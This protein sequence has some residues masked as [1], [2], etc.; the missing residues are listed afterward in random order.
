MHFGTTTNFSRRTFLGMRV[1]RPRGT[2]RSDHRTSL[3]PTP[4]PRT[5]HDLGGL[6]LGVQSYTLR[7][8][9]SLEA[10]LD[11]IQK[12]LGL[13]YVELYPGHLTGKS[14]AQVKELLDAHKITLS[15]WGVIH[16]G[17]RYRRK[18]QSFRE[19]QG[20]RRAAPYLRPRPRFLRQSR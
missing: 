14:P 12:D 13:S 1:P 6:P 8:I 10:A 5:A 19:R 16:F 11:A 9:R 7:K 17:K 3:R 18:P 4:L 20:A 15:G 2:G